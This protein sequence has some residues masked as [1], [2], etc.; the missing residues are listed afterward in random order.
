MGPAGID[1]TTALLSPFGAKGLE[2]DSVIIVEPAHIA[3]A[4]DARGVG[5]LYVALTRSTSRLRIMGSGESVL[6]PFV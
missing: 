4:G 3:P 1:H 5:E 6:S 2:F